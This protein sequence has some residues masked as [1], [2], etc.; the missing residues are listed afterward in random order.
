MKKILA[1]L[2]YVTSDFVATNNEDFKVLKDMVN[3]YLLYDIRK[4]VMQ[5]R[6][7]QITLNG[8]F[9]KDYKTFSVFKSSKKIVLKT[10]LFFNFGDNNIIICY[11]GSDLR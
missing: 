6:C 5:C 2:G 7:N 8:F 11:I 4:P 1:S 9:S 10:V 3:F